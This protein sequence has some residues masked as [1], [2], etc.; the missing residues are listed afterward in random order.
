MCGLH[1]GLPLSCIRALLRA[2]K[3]RSV[4]DK[5]RLRRHDTQLLARHPD[6]PCGVHEQPTMRPRRQRADLQHEHRGLRGLQLDGGLPHVAEH[7][8]PHDTAMRAVLEQRGLRRHIYTGVPAHPLRRVC[9]Q[10]RLPERHALLRN[11]G[12][13]AVRPMPSEC[14]VS[15]ERAKLQ[16]WH[17]RQVGRVSDRTGA[18]NPEEARRDHSKSPRTADAKLEPMP[19]YGTA[20]RENV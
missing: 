14:S 15:A 9:D 4:Q 7:L 20:A 8:R 12:S 10:R 6:V 18:T 3:L 13:P 2:G 1:D 5:H 19:A 17:L 11:G 16:R